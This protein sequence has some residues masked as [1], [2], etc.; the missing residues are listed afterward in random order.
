M[1]MPDRTPASPRA[2]AVLAEPRTFTGAIELAVEVAGRGDGELIVL[3]RRPRL[4]RGAIHLA[5][6]D[7][8]QLADDDAAATLRGV[9]GLIEKS[10]PQLPHRLLDVGDLPFRKLARMAE[11][12]GCSILVVP[13]ASGWAQLSRLRAAR[14]ADLELVTVP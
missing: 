2:V 6:Y 14:S 3:V 1:P 7:P 5:G 9:E 11:T 13:R 8:D 10:A 12:Y 4:L